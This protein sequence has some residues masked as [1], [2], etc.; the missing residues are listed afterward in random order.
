MFGD[1]RYITSYIDGILFLHPNSISVQD[2]IKAKEIECC[3]PGSGWLEKAIPES[4]LGIRVSQACYIHDKCWKY[5]R[6]WEGFHASNGVFLFN[7]NSI[8]TA[9]SCWLLRGVRRRLAFK[10]FLLVESPLG[11]KHFWKCKGEKS[12]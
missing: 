11:A 12:D 7:L 3:G 4:I 6:G 10:G 1:I 8:I 9:K 5:A 2:I